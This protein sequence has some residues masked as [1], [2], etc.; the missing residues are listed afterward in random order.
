[1]FTADRKRQILS[2]FAPALAS[3]EQEFADAVLV[4]HVKRVF[5]EDALLHGSLRRS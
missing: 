1:M 5:G 2:D 4:Q 3:N